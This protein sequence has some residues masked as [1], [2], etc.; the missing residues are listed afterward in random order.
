MPVY[1]EDDG[2][3]E[4]MVMDEGYV[5]LVPVNNREK[6]LAAFNSMGWDNELEVDKIVKE[7]G[8]GAWVANMDSTDPPEGG[9]LSD[10]EFV[11]Y[12]TMGD[13]DG[14]NHWYEHSVAAYLTPDGRYWA[15]EEQVCTF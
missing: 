14:I 1:D 3:S 2:V 6:T 15:L 12:V 5:E 9:V 8:T 11:I 4:M 7:L 13:G 10:E